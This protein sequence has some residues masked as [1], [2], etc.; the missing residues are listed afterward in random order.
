MPNES[1][2]NWEP[3]ADDLA[4]ADALMR[5]IGTDNVLSTAD[6]LGIEQARET[7]RAESLV[8]QCQRV[9][10]RLVDFYAHLATTP[11]DFEYR[12]YLKLLHSAMQRLAEVPTTDSARAEMEYDAEQLIEK[13]LFNL[14]KG[15]GPVESP[16]SEPEFRRWPGKPPAEALA[17]NVDMTK[18]RTDERRTLQ[19]DIFEKLCQVSD[20]LNETSKEF[21]YRFI[22][23]RILNAMTELTS[24]YG[25]VDTPAMLST[26]RRADE[27]LTTALYH[28]RKAGGP[29][30]Q[31]E[32][33]TPAEDYWPPR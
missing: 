8:E 6:H 21:E 14:R 26:Q 20:V 16:F 27:N 1:P 2:D 12:D 25:F 23:M 19:A 33:R 15:G 31:T 32:H 28:L 10:E 29:L 24:P 5:E 22:E 4:A 18:A 13:V 30:T 11:P 9:R 17:D 3:S 7:V